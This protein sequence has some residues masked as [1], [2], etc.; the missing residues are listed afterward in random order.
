MCTLA[1]G[2]AGERLRVA[3]ARREFGSIAVTGCVGSPMMQAV[4]RLG[5]LRSVLGSR[6]G[7]LAAPV[8]SSQTSVVWTPVV[9]VWIVLVTAVPVWVVLVARLVLSDAKWLVP[10]TAAH[11]ERTDCSSVPVL[12]FALLH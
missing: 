7:T 5:V 12:Q 3:A 1:V 6:I 4:L 11:G 10:V 9:P 2:F 8:T